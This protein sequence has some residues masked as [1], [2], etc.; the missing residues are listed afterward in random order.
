MPTISIARTTG[1]QSANFVPQI[2]TTALATRATGE[3]GN[4]D[5]VLTAAVR[6]GRPTVVERLLKLGGVIGCNTTMVRGV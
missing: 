3:H 6:A 1:A 2:V 4:G 5:T